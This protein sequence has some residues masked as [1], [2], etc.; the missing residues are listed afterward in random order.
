MFWVNTVTTKY[1]NVCKSTYNQNKTK[2]PFYWNYTGPN[3]DT[4]VQDIY[5]MSQKLYYDR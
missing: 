2:H 5:E 4:E 1:I 3:R